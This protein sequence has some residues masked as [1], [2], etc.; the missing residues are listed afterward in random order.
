MNALPS[1]STKPLLRGHFHQA[2][3]FI[4]LGACAM[5]I[6]TASGTPAITP[7]IIYSLG[8]AGLLGVSTLYHRP[9]WSSPKRL[10]MRRLDHSMIFI[11]I[12]STITPICILALRDTSGGKLLQITWVVATLGVTKSLLFPRTPK[13]LSATLFL[14]FGWLVVPYLPEIQASLDIESMALMFSGGLAYTFGAAIYAL[15]WP[16]PKPKVFGYHEIFHLLVV[17]GALFHFIMITKLV[18]ESV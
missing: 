7:S 6:T 10:W 12:A 1:P 16:N 13:W 5:L 18:H 4:A 3:F 15:K 14:G 11:L 17:L 2:A 9:T 8:L